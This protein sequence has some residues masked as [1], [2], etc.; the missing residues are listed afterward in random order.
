M[1]GHAGAKVDPGWPWCSERG[2]SWEG[3]APPT[4]N[5]KLVG[6]GWVSRRPLQK[7]DSRPRVGLHH[8]SGQRAWSPA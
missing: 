4:P 7:R 8:H 2:Q 1:P 3:D 5:G 6:G